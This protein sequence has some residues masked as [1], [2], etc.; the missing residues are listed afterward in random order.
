MT[1]ALAPELQL[2]LIEYPSG[3]YVAALPVLFLE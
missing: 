1:L 2:G 3:G